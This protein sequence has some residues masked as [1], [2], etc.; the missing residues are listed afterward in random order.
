ME[1]EDRISDTDE[2][3]Y[4]LQVG[5]GTYQYTHQVN[6]HAYMAMERVCGLREEVS[7]ELYNEPVTYMFEAPGDLNKATLKVKGWIQ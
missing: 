1:P 2:Q 4:W 7:P 6:K 3:T 5:E